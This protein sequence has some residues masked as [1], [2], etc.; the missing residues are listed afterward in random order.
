MLKSFESQNKK[1]VEMRFDGVEVTTDLVFYVLYR[2]YRQSG[3]L[4]ELASVNIDS[5]R[6]V[7]D[8]GVELLS[9]AA[10]RP[11]LVKK[12]HCIGC[13]EIYKYKYQDVELDMSVKD[14]FAAPLFNHLQDVKREAGGRAEDQ[15]NSVA[16]NVCKIEILNGAK[17]SLTKFM[18][19]GLVIRE[20]TPI[21]S[22]GLVRL[23]DERGQDQPAYKF[24]VVEINAV[25]CSLLLAN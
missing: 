14:I 8:F 24:N 22:Y 3:I 12:R 13:S 4:S 6:F 5:C 1:P 15:D 21:I 25:S 10:N 20:S 9:Y 11:L 16:L 7:T 2:F 17:L 19:N 18:Q 23:E